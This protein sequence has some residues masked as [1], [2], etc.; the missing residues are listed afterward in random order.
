MKLFKHRQALL[1]LAAACLL[2]VPVSA[3]ELTLPADALY[4]FSAEDF[5]ALEQDE[6]VFIT[7][8]PDS[9]TATVFHGSRVIRPGDALPLEALDQL[10]LEAKTVLGRDASITYY[11]VADGKVASAKE[12]RLSIMPQKNEPPTADAGSLETYKNISNTGKLTASDPEGEPLTYQIAKEPKRG[13]VDIAADGTFTYTPLEN[14]V[15]KDYFTYTVTDASGNVSQPAKIAIEIKKPEDKATYADMEGDPLEYAAMWMKE[16]GLF[17][18]SKIGKHLCFEPDAPITRGQFLVMVMGLVNAEAEQDLTA[19]GFADEAETE[20]W[21]RPYITTALMNGM[22]SG[23]SEEDGL[24]FRPQAHLTRAEAVVMLQNILDLPTAD[25]AAVFSHDEEASTPVWA[26]SAV[27][28]LSQAG[29]SLDAPADAET[30]TRRDA[31][32]LL[33][34]VQQLLNRQAEE[35]FYWVK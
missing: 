9:N 27:A 23:L 24:V 31:A 33:Q 1:I 8:V 14:K 25:S 29:I 3:L 13:S 21:L 7:S 6:G 10:T 12:L 11:T 20:L 22:I 15:G 19:S 18:G 2:A 30:A 28:A 17:T 26:Q 5:T 32:V 16:T 4:C 35:T 34:K